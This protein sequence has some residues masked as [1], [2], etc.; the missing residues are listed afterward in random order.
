M[1]LTTQSSDFLTIPKGVTVTVKNRNVTVTGPRG[2]LK[3]SFKH[4]SLDIQLHG[5][6]VT[7]E[8]WFGRKKDLA[9]IRTVKSHIANLITGVTQGFRYK[10]RLVS[11][12]FTVSTVINDDGSHI[13]LRKFLGDL[14]VRRVQMMEGVKVMKSA[15]LKD[16]LILEGNSID[17][18]SQSAAA[19]HGSCLVRNKDI[20]KFLDGVYV[21]ES[22]P[23]PQEE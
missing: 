12:H 23:I 10:M 3:K 7:V 18:V 20:R 16:E 13:E 17:N 5:N 8:R 9:C 14:D 15:E 22:G 2:T 11:A 21:S 1:P 19:I 6:K 4:L